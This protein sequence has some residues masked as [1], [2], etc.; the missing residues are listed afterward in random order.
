LTNFDLNKANIYENIFINL[1]IVYFLL[2]FFISCITC[3]EP[4]KLLLGMNNEKINIKED[5]EYFV[6]PTNYKHLTIDIK[7]IKN[8][9]K[10]II[11]D[12]MLD[13]CELKQCSSLSNICQSISNCL[14]L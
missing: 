6:L 4:R 2:I 5:C 14:Y 9:D 3:E 10:L 13:N 11:T 7:K 12:Q 1:I 8:I